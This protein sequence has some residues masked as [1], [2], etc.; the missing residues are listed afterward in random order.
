MGAAV[1]EAKASASVEDSTAIEVAPQA[2]DVVRGSPVEAQS[3]AIQSE[4]LV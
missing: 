2:I 1:A 3:N 4:K